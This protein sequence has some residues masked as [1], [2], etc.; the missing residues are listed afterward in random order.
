M[1]YRAPEDYQD[2]AEKVRSGEYFQEVRQM[3]DLNVH[4]PMAE[5]YWF[6]LITGLSL[7]IAL[8]T[9]IGMQSLYPLRTPVPLIVNSNNIIDDLPLI[10]NITTHSRQSTS[11]ALLEFMVKNFV[12]LREGYDIEHFDRN[13]NGVKS[14]SSDKV[15]AEYQQY[16]DPHNPQ[17]PITLYQR[18]STRNIEILAVQQEDGDTPSMTIVFEASVESKSEVKKSR[19][20]ANISFQ[21]SG[22]ALDEETGKVKPVTFI[23]TD[24]RTKRL[25][26][27]R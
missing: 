16:I 2:I 15:F 8:I 4:D 12:A 11:G 21:Y 19:W 5:R 1:D 17:S 7:F 25:Q 18:H 6:L 13:I 23:V 10:K 24:Y 26:D 20:Q 27:V 9:F 14:Q 3:Y 22:V